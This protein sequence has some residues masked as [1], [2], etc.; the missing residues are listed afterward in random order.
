MHIGRR[1]FISRTARTLGRRV[2][3][4]LAACLM[5]MPVDAGD[6]KSLTFM[7]HWLPQAQFA[8][9]YVA[10]EKGF[11]RQR[12]IDLKI[13]RGGPGFPPAEML[14]KNRVNVTSMFLSE[15]LQQ[16]DKNVKLINIGQ[17]MQ[18]S[19][20]ILVAKKGSGISKPEDLARRKVSLWE[21]FR[22]QPLAFFRKYNIAVTT[23]NQGATVNLFLRGGVDAAS[24]MWYNEY[25]TILNS[26]LNEEE[27]TTFFFDQHGLNFPEDGIYVLEE[28]FKKD[29]ALCR[30]FVRATLEGWQYAFEHQ[31]EALDAVM[32]Y[33]QEAQMGTN[34]V[35]QKW[36]LARMKD[37]MVPDG[38]KI[39][40]GIL[41]SIDYHM[42]AR[43]L[44]KNRL[45]QKIP[46]YKEFYVNC[47]SDSE[48]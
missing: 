13:L 5:A 10:Y 18:R 9:Y 6:L 34:R 37:L 27:L 23:V 17:L 15:A 38:E 16:R 47:A 46:S 26:G 12:G 42:V 29:P 28:T 19:G 1:P 11:Y 36:M 35:H 30:S 24:A 21:N 8:G 32:K 41:N 20:F 7:P 33:I 31:D 14:S 2:L 43:E 25:H 22:I 39:P 40:P 48:Q 4:I 3:P 44:I 45:I